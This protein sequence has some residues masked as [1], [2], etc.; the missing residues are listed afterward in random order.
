MILVVLNS[1]GEVPNMTY[2]GTSPAAIGQN[3]GGG[4]GFYFFDLVANPPAS[5]TLSGFTGLG[6]VSEWTAMVVSL[7]NSTETIAGVTWVSSV[8]P[9]VLDLTSNFAAGC[10][11]VT[12]AISQ[13]NL[14]VASTDSAPLYTSLSPLNAFGN[15]TV[16][17]A[18]Q[19]PTTAPKYTYSS[20]DST[21]VFNANSA[22]FYAANLVTA[23]GKFRG[24]KAHRPVSL[25]NVGSINPKIYA[26]G[27]NI[28]IK[29][30]S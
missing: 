19:S 20:T 16:L 11:M 4:P 26:P 5:T 15:G 24:Q 18:Y 23:Y 8:D 29:S 2:G 7:S 9:A 22:I 10:L 21:D 25:T 1:F 14:T 12:A 17:A 6:G 28:T 3:S 27:P 13:V 30:Q